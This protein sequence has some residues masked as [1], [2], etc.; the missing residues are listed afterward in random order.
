MPATATPFLGGITEVCIVTPDHL[1]TMDGLLRLG[2]GPFQVF[3]FTSTT[4]SARRFRGQDGDFSLKVCFAKQGDLVFEIM[5]P[6]GGKSLMGEWLDEVCDSQPSRSVFFDSSMTEVVNHETIADKGPLEY[7]RNNKEGV[8]HLAFD[9]KN[10]PM[11]ER[12]REMQARGFE[13]AMEGVW[14]GRK[15][16][17]TFCFFDTEASVGTVFESIEFS[18]DWEDPEHEWYPQAPQDK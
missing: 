10:I 3:D 1:K 7:K 14:K 8:Q 18:E 16:T 12:K 9:C 11:S 15:G 6:V 2:I 17:C 5:Q 4:V 13:P